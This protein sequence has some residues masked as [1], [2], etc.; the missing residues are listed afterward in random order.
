[1]ANNCLIALGS[2]RV[3][4]EWHCFKILFSVIGIIFLHLS[5]GLGITNPKC[6]HNIIKQAWGNMGTPFLYAVLQ[7]K[8]SLILAYL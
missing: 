4:F 7:T 3:S 8:K 2:V 6:C 5:Y 1:M